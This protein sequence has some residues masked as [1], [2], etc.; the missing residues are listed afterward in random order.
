[1]GFLNDLFGSGTAKEN[2]SFWKPL[3]SIEELDEAVKESEQKKVVIFKHS[4]RCHISKTVLDRF[5]KEQVEYPKDASFYLLDLLAFRPVSS[6][7]ESRLNITHQSPQLLVIE[8]GLVIRD[9]SHH[10]IS[11]SLV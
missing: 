5:E 3:T 11:L 8:N 7:I 1:M 2:A 4:T 6:E 10:S 9:A